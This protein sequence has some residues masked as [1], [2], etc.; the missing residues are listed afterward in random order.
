MLGQHAADRGAEPGA[1]RAVEQLV[2]A[3]VR[4][5]RR[6]MTYATA[7]VDVR[8][9]PGVGARPGPPG[10]GRDHVAG[11]SGDDENAVRAVRTGHVHAAGTSDGPRAARRH[12]G[13]RC[14]RAGGS[15][16]AAGHPIASPSDPSVMGCARPGTRSTSRA[17]ARPSTAPATVALAKGRIR[18]LRRAPPSAPGAAR[19]G[20]GPR[21]KATC[22]TRSGR[23]GRAGW[24]RAPGRARWPT[25]SRYGTRPTNHR[26]ICPVSASI[27][28]STSYPGSSLHTVI[29]RRSAQSHPC[30]A[31]GPVRTRWT[32][33][34]C[35]G[36]FAGI[37]NWC[38]RQMSERPSQSSS[39]GSPNT[40]SAAQIPIARTIGV[41]ASP[42]AVR[43]SPVSDGAVDEPAPLE[44]PKPL[45]ERGSAHP[46]DPAMD[47][48][49]PTGADHE[50][51]YDEGCP[52]VA[53]HVDTG[54][55]RAV[56]RV[57]RH[58]VMV[59]CGAANG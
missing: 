24:G 53:E 33:T 5:E 17:R 19:R 56:V 52:S 1:D 55:D 44:E 37:T 15:V 20:A 22:R 4:R 3:A 48:F 45:R 7:P 43:P 42:A 36:S 16:L 51:P 46:R 28:R 47:L 34:R 9:D 23:P 6:Q 41:N 14:R 26:C 27:A 38:I 59:G 8:G 31:P 58:V 12:G 13:Q 32:T 29:A 21:R 11:A 40:H 50:L 18:L 49:E 57:A 2:D 35:S 54:G 30:G 39:V 25:R 10:A